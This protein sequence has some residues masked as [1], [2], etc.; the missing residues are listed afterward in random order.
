MFFLGKEG[1][2]IT[3]YTLP[4]E[5]VIFRGLSGIHHIY[6]SLELARGKQIRST[7]ILIY[8]KGA[9]RTG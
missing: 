4:E 6:I 3:G 7:M 5:S 1:A 8:E 2:G 9:S